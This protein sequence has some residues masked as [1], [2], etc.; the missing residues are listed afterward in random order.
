MSARQRSAARMVVRRMPSRSGRTL[1]ALLWD[2]SIR[3][4]W[5]CSVV[6]P[7]STDG[8]EGLAAKGRAILWIKDARKKR[9]E[10]NKGRLNYRIC[11]VERKTPP[12]SIETDKFFFLTEPKK[13]RNFGI[14]QY[15][16]F[17]M[18]SA[19]SPSRVFFSDQCSSR[20]PVPWA[21]TWDWVVNF[22]YTN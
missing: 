9:K 21:T 14:S 20:D 8:V 12:E 1:E 7:A 2:C 3:S 16:A 6:V 22:K 4:R 10:R 15:I 17:V 13:E 5:I 18:Q 19:F 11:F